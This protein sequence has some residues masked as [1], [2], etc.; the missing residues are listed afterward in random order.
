MSDCHPAHLP[1]GPVVPFV[2]SVV[3]ATESY[4]YVL[5]SNLCDCLFNS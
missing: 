2:V 3:L 5:D 1:D 4:Y